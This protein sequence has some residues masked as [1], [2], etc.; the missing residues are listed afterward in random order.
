MLRKLIVAMAIAMPPS[1]IAAGSGVAGAAGSL[2]VDATTATVGCTGLDGVIVFR[3]PL[4]AGMGRT[5]T[6]RIR[7]TVSGCTGGGTCLGCSG[8]SIVRGRVT[9]TLTSR[10]GAEECQIGTGG[11]VTESGSLTIRWK[12]APRTP[13]LSSGSTVIPVSGVTFGSWSPGGPAQLTIPPGGPV[14]GSFQGHDQGRGDV[15]ALKA[16]LTPPQIDDACAGKVG[17]KSIGIVGGILMA[18]ESP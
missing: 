8:I 6:T 14:T 13:R 18:D 16:S 15:L 12:T 5:V 11:A 7:G 1:M 17:L 9:G 3:P 4:T 2:R 10:P